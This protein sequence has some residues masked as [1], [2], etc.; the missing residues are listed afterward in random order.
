MKAWFTLLRNEFEIVLHVTD[1][2]PRDK[3]W[4]VLDVN[5]CQL[6]GTFGALQH[7]LLGSSI[8][9]GWKAKVFLVCCDTAV[10]VCN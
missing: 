3:R 8:P 4:V 5:D 2:F 6:R 9:T 10:I 7:H 1:S